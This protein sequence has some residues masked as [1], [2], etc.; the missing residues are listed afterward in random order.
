VPKITRESFG[1]L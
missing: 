1:I